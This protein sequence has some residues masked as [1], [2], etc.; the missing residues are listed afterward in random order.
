MGGYRGFAA[1]NCDLMRVGLGLRASGLTEA[2]RFVLAGVG[3][4]LGSAAETLSLA[5]VCRLISTRLNWRRCPS[6]VSGRLFVSC[7]H[8]AAN[9]FELLQGTRL[10]S[11]EVASLNSYAN[12]GQFR[13]SCLRSSKRN[14]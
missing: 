3:S 5:V 6:F 13:K 11:L 7:R 12:Q 14:L 1:V 8:Q 10:A 2:R 4:R 9:A